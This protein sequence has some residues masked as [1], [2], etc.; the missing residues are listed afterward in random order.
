[1]FKCSECS[2][3]YQIKPDYC[4]CG[5]DI[6]IEI[7]PP[8]QEKTSSKE[9]AM[10]VSSLQKIFPI[11]FFILCIIL[12][13]LPWTIRQTPQKTSSVQ[14]QPAQNI[15]NIP[16]IEQ[17]W[18]EPKSTEQVQIPKPAARQVPPEAPVTIPQKP[19]VT[20]APQPQKPKEQK[21]EKKQPK[22]SIQKNVTVPANPQPQVKLPQPTTQ[23]NVQNVSTEI[24]KMDAGEFL[25]Y[26]GAIRNALLARLNLAAVKGEGECVIEFSV[27]NSGKLLNRRFISQ[28]SNKSVNDEVYYMLMRLPSFKKP[29][30]YY[31][32]EKI[33]FKIY[34]NN[35]YYE[36]S[37]VN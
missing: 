32:G 2:E 25:E 31:N 36:I 3:E 19:K 6:F 35:G 13:I 34:L 37:Y 11:A 9:F 16:S 24:K 10:P 30:Q 29:P 1:M 7:E 15:K 14:K 5:N 4:K 17:L 27:D 26:K 8:K 20:H 12:A 23:P 33:R 18:Q 22:P 21:I 28:S